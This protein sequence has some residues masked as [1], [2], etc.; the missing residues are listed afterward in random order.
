MHRRYEL[1]SR[2]DVL[3]LGH[4]FPETVSASRRK[5]EGIFYTPDYIVRHI[6]DHT[7]GMYL[8]EHEEKFKHEDY[9]NYQAFLRNL[10]ILD[11]ACGSGAFLV[12][13]FDVLL[14]ERQRV[15]AV[16]SDRVPADEY[17][18][19]ILREN[20]YGVDLSEE[21][22]EI[23]KQILWLKSGIRNERPT[24]LDDTIKCGN[25]L[26]EDPAF[27]S[28]RAFSWPGQFPEIMDAGGFDIVVGNPP[29]VNARTIREADK[30]YLREH[31]P[32]LH[33]AYDLYVAFLLRGR[34]L[35]KEHGRYGWIVPNK[36]LIADYADK[37]RDFLIKDSLTTV[38]DV[39][40]MD[41]FS[42]VG[43]YPVI[44]L[45]QRGK[46]GGLVKLTATPPAG[47]G[48][49]LVDRNFRINAGTT[50]FAAHAVKGLLN[51]DNR[52]IPFAVSG[53]VG[54]Y[55]LDTSSVRYMKD[56]YAHPYVE[57]GSP[58]VAA[59]KYR[60]WQSPKIV[61]AGMTKRI[62]AVYVESPL[63]LGV[64]AYGIYDLAGHEPFAVTAVLNSTFMSDYLR[65]AFHHKQLAGGYL[66]I[67]KSTIQQLPMP[68]QEALARTELTE[69][70]KR[71]HTC[72]P[73]LS[74]SPGRANLAE[75][76]RLAAEI[77]SAEQRIDEIVNRL[78]LV[79][80][81]PD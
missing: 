52:G 66:A 51:E 72:R 57:L 75:A 35:L 31:Y 79:R 69:L 44:L 23:T 68:D 58:V 62:E 7:L 78:F 32:Q 24:D 49:T 46:T 42:S 74:Q 80:R 11:P 70:S 37:A 81:I 65:A 41:V 50:G 61:V 17:V 25:S 21:S 9:R 47:G 33:G 8:R 19:Q 76:R 38:V 43:V 20:I 10:K 45:G 6:V 34:Q 54:R 15:G 3:A 5:T 48:Q 14:A 4:F 40:T 13:V 60:F 55:E 64:G 1:I 59:S 29:Y 2:D 36:F 28:Q 12:H 16:L 73:A 56:R 18:R 30:T 71:L 63:A 67:N 53:S 26:I 27:A 39:S 77:S 22:A